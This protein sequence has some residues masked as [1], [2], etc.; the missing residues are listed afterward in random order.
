MVDD[1][2]TDGTRAVIEKFGPQVTYYYQQNKGT[3]AARNAGVKLSRGNFLAFLDGDD[4]YCKEKLAKQTQAFCD[5]PGVDMVMTKAENFYSPELNAESNAK[6]L[7][8]YEP[9]SGYIP[10]AIMI[11]RDAFFRVGLFHEGYTIGEFI[12]WY[13]KAR[14]TQLREFV[15]PEVLVKRRIHKTNKGIV[16]RKHQKEYLAVLRE[17]IKRERNN[18]KNS[19]T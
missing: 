12:D 10:T 4:L 13:A 7:N 9:I 2:S 14:E 15:I 19:L 3:A 6:L 8:Q 18:K 5:M 16:Y 17:K 1:G 11:S